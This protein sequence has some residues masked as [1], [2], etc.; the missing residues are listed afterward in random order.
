MLVD[1]NDNRK[2]NERKKKPWLDQ[3]SGTPYW[4]A[5]RSLCTLHL[6]LSKLCLTTS[7]ELRSTGWGSDLAP[8]S[9]RISE[10]TGIPGFNILHYTYAYM[11]S[12]YRL[13]NLVIGILCCRLEV[14]S[15]FVV[16]IT[17]ENTS[18]YV[19][20]YT[21]SKYLRTYLLCPN[22]MMWWMW[23]VDLGA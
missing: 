17:Y 19:N 1:S 10:A 20:L 9:M 21:K 14:R 11:R 6:P 18:I 12:V 13:C 5:N 2:R 7:K 23:S 16:S 4:D 15:H 22:V 3:M 8:Y